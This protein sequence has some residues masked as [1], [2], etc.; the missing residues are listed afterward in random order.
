MFHISYPFSVAKV[1]PNNPINFEDLC[2]ISQRWGVVSTSL[3]P[4][5][6]GLPFIGC[7]GL[8]I[9]YIHKWP[10][11][12][13]AVSSIR[14][15]RTHHTVVKGTHI[16]WIRAATWMNY[17]VVNQATKEPTD[18]PNNEVAGRS[19]MDSPL[20]HLSGAVNLIPSSL[21]PVPFQVSNHCLHTNADNDNLR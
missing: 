9:Q 3:N 10:S 5:A 18:R 8:L 4:Q 6:G 11:D 14:N 20:F 1:L 21:L 2:N 7:P 19:P 16:K 12:L 15:P 17:A 13:D